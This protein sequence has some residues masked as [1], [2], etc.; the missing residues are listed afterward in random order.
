MPRT[1]ST[2]SLPVLFSIPPL[3]LLPRGVV[4]VP[5]LRPFIWHPLRLCAGR[6]IRR[7]PSYVRLLLS[8]SRS[9]S[10]DRG[11]AR[12]RAE[13]HMEKVKGLGSIAMPGEGICA[14]FRDSSSWDGRWDCI[15]AAYLNIGTCGGILIVH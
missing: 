2:A 1:A 5:P 6:S 8:L 14:R 9:Q 10:A 3:H 13:S 4:V 11:K 7:L 12:S 15:G